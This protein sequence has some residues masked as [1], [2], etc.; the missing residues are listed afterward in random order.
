MKKKN[1]RICIQARADGAGAVRLFRGAVPR[2][3]ARGVVHLPRGRRVAHLLTHV[4]LFG[5][6]LHDRLV[7][8]L[9]A[10]GAPERRQVPAG[11]SG[12]VQGGV[13]GDGG[14]LPGGARARAR[15]GGAALPPGEHHRPR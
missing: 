7:R 15:A 14:P 8:G 12:H 4:P 2:E 9:A 11:E 1:P 13:P 3:P 5:Q 10:R 6:L